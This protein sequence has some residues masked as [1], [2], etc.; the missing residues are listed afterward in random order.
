MR[1][2]PSPALVC[3]LALW[4]VIGV[5]TTFRRQHSSTSETRR[6]GGWTWGFALHVL[7][8]GILWALPRPDPPGLWLSVIAVALGAASA[9]VILAAQ[10]A[11]GRQFAYTARLVEGHRLIVAGPYRW[12]RHPIYTALFGMA[13][14]NGLVLSRWPAIAIFVVLYFAGT[15]I[16]IRSEERLLRGEFGAEFEDYAARV[17]ALIPV[18]GRKL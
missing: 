2:A 16:R 14:A 10:R 5:A 15:A 9:A 18:P 7:S 1:I 13:L 12:V 8:I 11:L 3:I 6:A 17:P 4:I